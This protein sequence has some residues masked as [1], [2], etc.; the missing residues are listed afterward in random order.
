MVFLG[1]LVEGLERQPND[2]SRGYMTDAEVFLGWVETASERR[3][4]VEIRTEKAMLMRY[5]GERL[6]SVLRELKAALRG[7]NC[8]KKCGNKGK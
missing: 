2:T 4:V 7:K 6:E 1:V 5:G 3:G 8:R